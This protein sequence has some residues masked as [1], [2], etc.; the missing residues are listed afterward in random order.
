MCRRENIPGFGQGKKDFRRTRQ[1]NLRSQTRDRPAAVGCIAVAVEFLIKE[2]KHE[3]KALRNLACTAFMA[4][5]ICA[6]AG[7]ATAETDV[8]SNHQ[9][10]PGVWYTTWMGPENLEFGT[11]DAGV[12]WQKDFTGEVV[13]VDGK[14]MSVDIDGSEDDIAN[15]YLYE[16][17]TQ[18]TPSFDAI[19]VGSKIEVRADNRN[20]VRSARTIPFYQWLENQSEK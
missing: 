14:Y 17:L 8:Q 2:V 3:M 16:N 7:V 9:M 18:Y 10:A 6:S 1:H 12:T 19:R 4:A 20:R 15:F 5:V 13:Y 11:P